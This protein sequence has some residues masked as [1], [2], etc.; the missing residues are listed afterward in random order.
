M[1]ATE[2]GPLQVRLAEVGPLQVRLG[3]VG[4]FQM[5]VGYS[6]LHLQM[7]VRYPYVLLAPTLL[8]QPGDIGSSEQIALD[9]ANK[10]LDEAF[11]SYLWLVWP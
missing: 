9:L 7:H 8:C 6:P 3:K 4:P 10:V 2:V 11:V 1:R 5:Q